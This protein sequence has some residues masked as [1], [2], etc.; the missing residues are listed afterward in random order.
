MKSELNDLQKSLRHQ[1]YIVIALILLAGLACFL[2]YKLG[3][4]AHE[5]EILQRA[6]K[7]LNSDKDYYNSEDLEIVVFG[8]SQL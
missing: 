6:K 5:Q 7:L 8:E 2:T 1:L 4:N 3:Y